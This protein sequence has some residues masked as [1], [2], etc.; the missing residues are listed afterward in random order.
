[1]DEWTDGGLDASENDT[2]NFIDD[3]EIK[4]ESGSA[5]QSWEDW[6]NQIK[7]ELEDRLKPQIDHQIRENIG[8]QILISFI[9]IKFYFT[10]K[11][12]MDHRYR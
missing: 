2:N 5:S 11:T 12:I 4:S 8:K 10:I 9:N 6:L 1:M 3:T 7:S